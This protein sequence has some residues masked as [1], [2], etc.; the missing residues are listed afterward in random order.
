MIHI[1]DFVWYEV[2]WQMDFETEVA[3]APSVGL[4]CRSSVCQGTRPA[5]HMNARITDLLYHSALAGFDPPSDPPVP[6]GM[7]T[8]SSSAAVCTRE[9][10]GHVPT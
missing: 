6:P 8:G 2:W 10:A 9:Q 7:I 1:S 3:G 4:N 5:V